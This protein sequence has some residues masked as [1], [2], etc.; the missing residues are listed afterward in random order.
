VYKRQT[1]DGQ[2]FLNTLTN[3][4]EE[5]VSST[6]QIIAVNTTSKKKS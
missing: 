3:T 6:R 2:R 5:L 4:W 1:K